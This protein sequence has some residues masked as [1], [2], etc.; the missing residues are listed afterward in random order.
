MKRIRTEEG[1]LVPASYKSGR[2]E[3]WQTQ[4]KMKYRHNDDDEDGENN[5]RDNRARG[6]KRMWHTKG[7][8]SRGARDE[9][10]RPE[11]ILKARR[12][13]ESVQNY[14]EH[15]R[16]ENLKRKIGSIQKKRGNVGNGKSFKKGGSKPSFGRK[17]RR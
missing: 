7:N 5:E 3:K 10:K 11:Q 15:R 12:K 6:R 14:Q 17:S 1:T 13:K 9:V 2:Y 16:Q 4:Q 8:Q